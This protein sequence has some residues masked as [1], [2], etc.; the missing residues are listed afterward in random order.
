MDN[1][2]V[3]YKSVSHVLEEQITRIQQVVETFSENIK[4]L[5]NIQVAKLHTAPRSP[6]MK[7]EKSGKTSEIKM[8]SDDTNIFA[9]KQLN[10]Y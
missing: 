6:N 1:I 2:T 5:A 4:H 10:N 9:C 3:K 8:K 7:K